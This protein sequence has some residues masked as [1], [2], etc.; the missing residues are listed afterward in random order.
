MNQ[1][2]VDNP[3]NFGKRLVAQLWTKRLLQMT[4]QPKPVLFGSLHLAEVS[5]SL[6]QHRVRCPI[7]ILEELVN[8]VLEPIVRVEQGIEAG[9]GASSA[10]NALGRRSTVR[11]SATMT[12]F[13]PSSRA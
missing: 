9:Q 13:L 5:P 8:E 1:Y 4:D 2:R 10:G 12:I 6:E 11:S 3:T 7:Q